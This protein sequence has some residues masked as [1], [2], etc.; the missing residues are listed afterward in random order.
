MAYVLGFIGHSNVG[1]TTLI[2]GLI[3]F[4]AKEGKLI[5]A[6]KHDAHNFEIDHQGKDSYI[7]KQAGANAVAISS[8]DKWAFIQD[9]K[10]EKSLFE[11]LGYF[12]NYDYIFVEGYKLEK[13]QKIEVYRESLRYTPLVKSGIKNIILVATDIPQHYFGIPTRHIDD[14]L[15]IAEFIKHHEHVTRMKHEYTSN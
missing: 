10:Q 14:V 9:T 3:S 11:L 6:I 8:K 5:G 15:G 13:I 7:L 12:K 1:K 2:A 4:F